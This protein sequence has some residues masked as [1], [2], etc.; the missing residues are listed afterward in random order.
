MLIDIDN[1]K[2]NA[3]IK[4]FLAT[5]LEKLEEEKKVY[6]TKRTY[7]KNKIDIIASVRPI[8]ISN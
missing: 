5:L 6:M 2:K 1:N 3:A 8:F 4:E 7:L